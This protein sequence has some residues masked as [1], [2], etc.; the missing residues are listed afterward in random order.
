MK[1]LIAA[2]ALSIL[3][4]VVGYRLVCSSV[5]D[6]IAKWLKCWMGIKVM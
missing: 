4:S 2:L 6:R 5:R 3:M 1:S